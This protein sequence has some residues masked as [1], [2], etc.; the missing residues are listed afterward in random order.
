MQT[1]LITGAA[2]GIG[3]AAAGHFLNKGWKVIAVD[4]AEFGLAQLRASFATLPADRL[5]TATCDVTSSASVA[6]A[7]SDALAQE[8]RLD[9]LVCCAG[10]LRTGSV[11]DTSIEDYNALF[12]VNTRGPWL[13]M[14]AALPALRRA[15]SAEMPSR[16]VMISSISAIRPKAGSGVYAASKVALSHLVRVLAAECAAEQILVN[17]IAPG[18][19]QTPFIQG[20][21]AGTDRKGGFKLSGAAPLGRVSDPVD[22][23]HVIDFLVAEGS[24]FI[25]GVTLP[26]DGGTSAA[27]LQQQSSR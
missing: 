16:V 12:D 17:A 24:R 15:A 19:V 5:V 2:S 6:A 21:L 23:V 11:A 8:A 1:V 26:V 10:I 7:F 25:T 22:I 13:C 20:A 27:L 9:A 14:K 4:R 3:L 18:T